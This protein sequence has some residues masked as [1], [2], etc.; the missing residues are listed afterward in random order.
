[1]KINIHTFVFIII[2]LIELKK[3]IL[4]YSINLST[5]FFLMATCLNKLIC[6]SGRRS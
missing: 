2:I 5:G 4:L 6:I 3:I 1:M